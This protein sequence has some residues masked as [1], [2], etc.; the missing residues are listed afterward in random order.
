[1]ADP[2]HDTHQLP[3]SAVRDALE[4][5][6]L[7]LVLQPIVDA[8]TGATSAYEGLLRYLS[9]EGEPVSASPLIE[10]A[11][12]DGSIEQIDCR[13]LELGVALLKRHP[14][15]RL[16]LNV[17]TL[18]AHEPGWLSLLRALRSTCP[19]LPQRLVIE[20]TETAMIRD[21]DKMAAFI[22]DVHA[23]GARIAIDDF[24]AGYTS[25]RHL[26]S[27][28][29]DILKID[30]AFINDLPIEP[31]S[32]VIAKTMIDMAH[33]LGMTTV[34]E[35][36]ANE[37]AAVFLREAGVTALQ[38]FLYG[39]PLSCEALAAI[40]ETAVDAQGSATATRP[41]T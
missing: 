3:S 7:L 21:L 25:F 20:I 10:H 22:A 11:E 9:D 31:Q 17:S 24:G 32:R 41:P 38:G 26:K 40:E 36:V 33:A 12:R 23:L 1:M 34:A 4:G 5:D 29:A 28:K 16:S 15:I 35:W 37:E 19:D 2:R 14:K 8:R 6:R 39:Q 27:L 18:T 13:A 30:G